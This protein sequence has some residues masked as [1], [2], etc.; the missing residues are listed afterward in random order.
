MFIRGTN[1]YYNLFLSQMTRPDYERDLALILAMNVNMVRLH[2]HFSNPE[3]YDLADEKGILVW[4]DY[5]E[6]WYPHDRRFSLRAARLYDNHIRYVRNHPSIALW[7]TSDEED[8]E[9]YRDLTAHLAPRAALLD[10]QHRPVVRSTG[11]YGDA[12]LYYG[13]YGGSV[14]QYA[15][16]DE[17]FVSEL[18]ATALPNY[19]SLVRFLPRRMADPGSSGCLDFP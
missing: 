13:W 16:M 17:P 10:P 3:F 9:N 2:C 15:K 4:Q 6:A 18:G 1:S 14:W 19:E 8:F 11:R 12:H 5:L 7:A